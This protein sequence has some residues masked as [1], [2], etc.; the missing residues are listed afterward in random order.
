MHDRVPV[1]D[2]A[3]SICMMIQSTQLVIS[4][5]CVQIENPFR[6]GVLPMWAYCAT[7]QHDILAVAGDWATGTRVRSTNACRSRV[8]IQ[9]HHLPGNCQ[10]RLSAAV[11]RRQRHSLAV[12]SVL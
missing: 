11:C 9:W 1:S 10:A 3:S 7:I 12:G 5:A 2:T 4:W 6:L 8:V